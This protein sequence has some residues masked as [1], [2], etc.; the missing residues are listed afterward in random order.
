ARASCNAQHEP[1][2]D[3]R[4]HARTSACLDE[5][6]AALD[7]LVTLFAAADRDIV[8]SAVAS[9]G[10]LPRFEDCMD[11]ARANAADSDATKAA[12]TELASVKA[13]LSAGRA[14]ESLARAIAVAARVDVEGPRDL[15]A[16]AQLRLANAAVETSDYIL[17]EQAYERG[18]HAA[19]SA[20]NDRVAAELAL[21]ATWLL[22][23]QLE[24]FAT[25]DRWDRIAGALMTRDADANAELFGRRASNTAFSLTRRGDF[26]AAE[27]EFARAQA[28][29][30]DA[31][32]SDH[33]EIGRILNGLAEA[34][35]RAGDLEAA[36]TSWQ[37]AGET[38][39]ELLGEDHPRMANV[40][41]G[42][43]WIAVHRGQLDEA[44]ARY[45]EAL[46]LRERAFGSDHVEVGVA[47]VRVADVLS[48]LGRLDEAEVELRRAIAIYEGRVGGSYL[49][50]TLALGNLANLEYQRSHYS[51][52]RELATR[53]L[54]LTEARYGERHREVARLL[55]V[56]ANAESGMGDN[57]AARGHLQR[58]VE[59]LETTVGVDAEE[60]SPALNNLANAEVALGDLAAAERH[61]ARAL[62]LGERQLGADAI[63]N[64]YPVTGLGFVADARRDYAKAR[65]FHAR[66][67]QIREKTLPADHPERGFSMTYLAQARTKL[68]EHAEARALLQAAIAIFEQHPGHVGLPLALIANGG[69]ELAED[70]AAAGL[71]SFERA[72]PL[73]EAALADGSGAATTVAS[74]QFGLARALRETGGSTRRATELAQA[75]ATTYA[76]SG[77]AEA[78]RLEEVRAWLAA[79]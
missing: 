37:R 50:L 3:A 49:H 77:S 16:L 45:R 65:D 35:L 43:G 56:L 14:K 1:G 33:V 79:R 31:L 28:L 48:R 63:S 27:R 60:V 7:T 15:I 26:H 47:L 17:A 69:N 54:A 22:G 78:E 42:F 13:L 74:A 66:A 23:Y 53:A 9:I 4:N 68:G 40:I 10:S 57:E 55:N 62:A 73:A 20:G 41:I 19:L 25:A 71:A 18:F 30:E 59:V 6:R 12:R 52:S 61:Y 11:P 58:A 21:G 70:H 5:G 29:T 2:G 8:Q 24:Q 76:A 64:A 67:L 75:A 72:L 46:A 44:L 39:A 32:G 51:R 38:L 34:Q 36:R